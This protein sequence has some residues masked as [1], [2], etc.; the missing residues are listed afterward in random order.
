MRATLDAGMRAGR[1]V[2]TQKLRFWVTEFSWDTNPPDPNAMPIALQSRWVSEA[3][4]T[5]AQSGVSLA[6]W[7]LIRDEPLSSPYQ[8]GLY[9]RNGRP[10]PSLQAFRFPFVAFRRGDSVTVWGRTPSERPATVI[11]EH[12]SGGAWKRVGALASNSVGVFRG[13]FSAPSGDWLRARMTPG[14]ATSRP[15]S[16]TEP[17]DRF[18]RPFG[19]PSSRR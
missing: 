1:I 16:L 18:Y 5:M 14:S 15:F 4:Y 19:E 7:Y 13:R 9:F 3:L 8:S 2:T 17:A 12:R 10:K 6:T 11:V